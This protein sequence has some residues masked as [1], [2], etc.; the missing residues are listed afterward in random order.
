MP[1]RAAGDAAGARRGEQLNAN[2]DRM[3][4][5]HVFHAGGPADVVKHAVLARIL[6]HLKTKPAAFRVIDTHAGAGLY[7]LRGPE[8]T[9]SPEWRDGIARLLSAPIPEPAHALLA[10]YLDIV[11]ALNPDGALTTYPGSPLLVR[12]LLRSQDRLVACELEPNA[13]ASLTHHLGRERRAKAIAIDGWTALNAYLPPPERR[14]LVL[15]DPPFEAADEFARLAQAVETAHRKWATG[16]FLLWYPLKGRQDSDALA[17][18]LRRS[19]IPKVLRGEVDFAH[20]NKPDGLSGCG[21]IVVNPPWMLSDEM[22]ILL[23]FLATIFAG[24]HRIDW[25]VPSD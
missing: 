14:G 16:I 5:R 1:A 7:D 6:I 11:R 9:R 3:N 2:T 18:R 22:E 19:A 15:V 8:A 4:Y 12:A 17:R 25:I 24:G 23:T 21:L 10:S 20:A 13:A